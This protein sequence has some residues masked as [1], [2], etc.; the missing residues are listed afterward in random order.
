MELALFFKAFVN[1]LVGIALLF[2]FV[3]CLIWIFKKFKKYTGSWFK[4]K[5]F[6]R[7]Y[8]E[9]DVKLLIP[10]LDKMKSEVEVM[11]DLLVYEEIKKERLQDL[12]YVYREMQGGGKK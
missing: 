6:K 12:M 5:I 9:E 10:Y 11:K 4:Y 1:S 7:K 3:F 2:W 8:K